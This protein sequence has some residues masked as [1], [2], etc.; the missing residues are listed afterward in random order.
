MLIHI[1]HR[2]YIDSANHHGESAQRWCYHSSLPSASAVPTG[3]LNDSFFSHTCVAKRETK[4]MKGPF[5]VT[6]SFPLVPPHVLHLWLPWPSQQTLPI[7]RLLPPKQTPQFC[8]PKPLYW[9]FP[10][11]SFQLSLCFTVSSLP[12]HMAGRRVLFLPILSLGNLRHPSLK[13]MTHN[14]PPWLVPTNAS[15]HANTNLL[16]KATSVALLHLLLTRQALCCYLD[17]SM[18][19]IHHLALCILHLSQA[20][21]FKCN[22]TIHLVRAYYSV[23]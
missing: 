11:R 12:S 13:P 10:P 21:K 14:T 8:F 3:M 22:W 15:L 6:F 4:G 9:Q 23:L 20:N 1:L 2:P 5:K 17:P 16:R 7:P 19:S 18:S